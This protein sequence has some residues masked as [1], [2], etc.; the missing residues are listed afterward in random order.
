MVA[1]T[2]SPNAAYF[3]MQSWWNTGEMVER[4]REAGG[5]FWEAGAYF[6]MK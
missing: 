6:Q 3:V 2:L 4:C 5:E 1:Q